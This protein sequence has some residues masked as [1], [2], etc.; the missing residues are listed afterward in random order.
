MSNIVIEH[1]PDAARLEGL[2]VSKWPTWEKEVSTF[3]WHFLEQEIA[4]ILQGECVITPEGGAPVTFGKGDLVT[5]P[6]GMKCSW[7]V[8]QPLHKHYHLEGSKLAQ[9]ARRVRAMLPF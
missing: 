8:R 7:E 5:F 6:A 2:G 9:I 4:W 3:P 1:N